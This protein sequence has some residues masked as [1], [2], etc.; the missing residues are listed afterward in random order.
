M[1]K[2]IHAAPGLLLVAFC[3]ILIGYAHAGPDKKSVMVDFSAKE[4]PLTWQTVNDDV[5][6]GISTS[7]FAVV[8][9]VG[10]F[11]GALSLE[12]SGGF[13]SVRSTGPIPVL[14][15]CEALVVRVKG[16]GRKYQLRV[17]TKTGGRAD[18]RAEFQTKK[19][20]WQEHRLSLKNFVP[21][22][23]GDTLT[24][25][26]PLDPATIESIGFLL[27]DKT[28]GSFALDIQWVQA[29]AEAAKKE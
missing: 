2:T 10:Q 21:T 25:A 15:G 23:R 20:E 24:D 8:E 22:W 4:T 17:R 28:A 27:G 13:A 7:R 18:Y 12:N 5:M 14:P 29:S 11:R 1:K 9:G 16:D 3:M 19:D 6:G 26:P